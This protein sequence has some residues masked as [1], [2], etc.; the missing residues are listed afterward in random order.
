MSASGPFSFVSLGKERKR[1]G[2][3]QKEVAEKTGIPLGT[4]RRWEQGQNDPDMGSL[5]Q[6]ANLYN[7]SLDLM[8]GRD[9]ADSKSLVRAVPS[10]NSHA[11]PVVGRIAAG[12]PREALSQSDSTRETTDETFSLHPHAFWLEVAG[13]SMNRLF[14]EGSLVLIDPDEEV[15]NGDVAAIFINGDDATLKRV[16]FEGDSI[17]LHPESYD[18]EYPDRV[19]DRADPDAPAVRTIGKAVSFTASTG[20][21]A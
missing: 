6:L 5:V 16:F 20:W 10:N 8:L 13:N 15:R 14:P 12:T 19:I 1:A 9:Q 21:R 7:S 17:R 4:L 3:T 18:P 11:L 2:F